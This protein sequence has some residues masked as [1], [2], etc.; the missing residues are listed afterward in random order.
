MLSAGFVE[1][2]VLIALSIVLAHLLTRLV[3][4]PIRRWGWANASAWR[5]AAVVGMVLVL[6]LTP[7]VLYLYLIDTAQADAVQ[8]AGAGKPGTP[9]EDVA[10]TSHHL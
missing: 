4:T 8:R 7:I 1:G 2:T 5:S 3:D 9:L 10:D 6:A